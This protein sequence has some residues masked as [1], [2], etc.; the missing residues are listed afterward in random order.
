MLKTSKS[1]E[2]TTRPE[3]GGV[4]V[5]GDG[6]ENDSHDDGG[7]RSG[8]AHQWTHQLVRPRSRSSM[9]R[10]MVLASWSKR[11]VGQ[12]VVKKLKNRQKV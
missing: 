2:S 11:Q 6:G 9:M 10:L 1:T 12:K 5:G 3:K 8:Q 7:G 4:E